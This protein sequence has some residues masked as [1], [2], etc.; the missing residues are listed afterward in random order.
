MSLSSSKSSSVVGLSESSVF[1]HSYSSITQCISTFGDNYTDN[2]SDNYT[3]EVAAISRA[4]QKL[5]L[6]YYPEQTSYLLVTDV[7]PL[8]KPHSACLAG[9]KYVNIPNNV[10]P[11]NKS[12]G[13]GYHY[14]YTNVHYSPPQGGSNWSLPLSIDRVLSDSD[15]IKTAHEQLKMLLVNED[16]PFKAAQLIRQA[17]DSG[18]TTPRY[19]AP[20]VDD[21]DN[22][23][24]NTRFRHGSKVWQQAAEVPQSDKKQGAATVYGQQTYYLQANSGLKTKPNGKT[25][26][27]NSK[28]Y[29]SIYDLPS[30]ERIE[31]QEQTYKKRQ[32]TIILT[33]WDNMMIR[34]K[35]G[36]SMK[37]KP[38]NLIAS[39]VVDSETGELIFQ[40][41][42]FIGIFGKQKDQIT[43]T[44]AFEDYRNRYGI[45]PHNRFNKQQLLLDKYQTPDVDNLDKWTL[46]VA[47]AYWLLFVA[48]D[49]VDTVVKPWERNLP[50]HK[51]QTQLK[52][53]QIAPKK[54]IAQVK[55]A[56][57]KLFYTFD[58]KPFSPKS[59]NNGKGRKLGT[60]CTKRTK[61]KV[62]KKSDFINKTR[63]NE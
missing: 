3:S 62:T 1:E 21:Y 5:W 50:I 60:K 24:L 25:K 8:Q 49:E 53:D 41:P 33:R 37:D 43:T 63:K 47:C 10:I 16:L 13:I 27:L 54:S 51:Q 48:A 7:T 6:S 36:N 9:R 18:Y 17:T 26:E 34:T 38:F 40:K 31:I 35:D 52:Q 45:E 2:Y 11:M 58:R 55:K 14:S 28:F 46:I 39:Q 22:L 44:Q 30:T 56:A 19:I 42:M 23:V 15:A 12:L 32:I 61:H 29:T 4:L 57:E 59:V 20:L